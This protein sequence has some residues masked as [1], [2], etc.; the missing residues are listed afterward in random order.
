MEELLNGSERI[1]YFYINDE[2]VRVGCLTDNSFN[3]DVDMILTTTR[4]SGGWETSRP[5]AQRFTISFT[6]IQINTP[7]DDSSISY[8][9]IKVLKRNRT[10]ID[11]K[12]EYLNGSTY[13]TG[14]AYIQRL[15]EAAP[16]GDFLTFDGELLGY[17]LPLIISVIFN[18]DLWQNGVEMILQNGIGLAF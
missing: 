10:I 13:D 15:G 6:G 17:G 11:W 8:D 14:K 4:N 18:A 3:E 7:E 9:E 12:I 2:W 5:G 1:L 16:A